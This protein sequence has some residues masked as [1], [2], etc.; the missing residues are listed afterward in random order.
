M[1]ALTIFKGDEGLAKAE[2]ALAA[3]EARLAGLA[4]QREAKLSDEGVDVADVLKLDHEAADIRAKM[5]LQSDRIEALKVK[6][7]QRDHEARL[8]AKAAEIARLRKLAAARND[9]AT[10]LDVAV[11]VLIQAA[12]DLRAAD[13]ALF[14]GWNDTLLPARLLG[15]LRS[16]HNEA[17]SLQRREKRVPGCIAYVVERA[18][19][20]FG[21]EAEKLGAELIVELEAAPLPEQQTSEDAA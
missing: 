6:Q 12:S 20:D 19:F 4:L 10:K 13:D 3:F 2:Q 14:D 8:A 15:Y 21:P 1:R 11:R 18:A 9:K 7:R 16:N 17:L 5:Q